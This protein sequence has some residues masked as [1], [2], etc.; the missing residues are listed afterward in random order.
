MSLLLED[1]VCIITG[2]GS[3]IGAGAAKIFAREGARLVLVG[4]TLKTLEQTKNE[5]TAIGA[6]ALCITADV[7]KSAD[8][9]RII[10][11]T[12]TTFARLDCALNN[13]AID[14]AQSLTADYPEDIWDEVIAVNLKGVWNC[15]R[16][17]IRQM[18]K[19]GGGAILN[20]SSATTQP[21]Q[22]MMSA[23]VASKYAVNGLT[24][25]AGFEYAKQNIRING[26]LLG[27]IETQM[28][29]ELMTQY[30]TL[31]DTVVKEEAIG[32]LGTVEE[33]GEAAA[34][35]LSDRNSFMVGTNVLVD[36]GYALP[37][38]Q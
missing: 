19:N 23:Y 37:R 14:G 34:W 4:R 26:L 38:R 29:S 15:M 18:L 30:P 35:L 20:V 31:R 33:C 7:S 21:M 12:L 32:R 3:G 9:A 16:Y 28:V 10:E 24:K 27:C 13:A 5:V 1:K 25:N 17:Q 11:E 22:P 6:R 2:A 36:G 8:C